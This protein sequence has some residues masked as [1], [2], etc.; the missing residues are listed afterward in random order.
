MTQSGKKME[1]FIEKALKQ[2]VKSR[3]FGKQIIRWMGYLIAYES[4]H[5]GQILL[6]LKQN[7]FR[8]PEKVTVQ[9]LWGK[10]ISGK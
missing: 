3:M 8:L 6:A 7:G 1:E 2:D 10:W 5:R 4:H 9:G